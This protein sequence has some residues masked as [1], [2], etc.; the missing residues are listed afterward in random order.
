[1][2]SGIVSPAMTDV[3]DLLLLYIELAISAKFGNHEMLGNAQYYGNRN[4]TV[5]SS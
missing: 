1:M 2:V 3:F 4:Q 5:P